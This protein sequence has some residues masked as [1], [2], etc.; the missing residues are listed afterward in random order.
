MCSLVVWE[1]QKVCADVMRTWRN[2]PFSLGFRSVHIR[3]LL[4]ICVTW[5][6]ISGFTTITTMV[7][8]R[9]WRMCLF[10]NY[11]RFTGRRCNLRTNL[12]S[13]PIWNV[14]GKYWHN[15]F[16]KNNSNLIE[17][18]IAVIANKGYSIKCWHPI[19]QYSPK[20]LSCNIWYNFK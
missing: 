9:S 16:E 11:K 17:S 1:K 8:F 14:M 2:F 3:P 7:L 5:I 19:F 6:R 20:L 15:F 4:E 13:D 10:L 18:L 12:V